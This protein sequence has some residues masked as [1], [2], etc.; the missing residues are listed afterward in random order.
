MTQFLLTR[1][2]RAP[3][4]LRLNLYFQ[5]LLGT[6]QGILK[7][8][9]SSDTIH[10]PFDLEILPPSN[11]IFIIEDV[12]KIFLSPARWTDKGGLHVS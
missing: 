10:V 7:F 5:I 9:G 11:L 6:G 2:W 1:A 3:G 4:L 12:L 8:L